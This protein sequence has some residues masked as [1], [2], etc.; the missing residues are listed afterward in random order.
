[1]DST[2]PSGRIPWGEAP[3]TRCLANFR[4]SL[5]DEKCPPAALKG[6]DGL[7]IQ[8]NG[9]FHDLIGGGGC[10]R[11]FQKKNDERGALPGRKDFPTV[12][13]MPATGPH[14]TGKARHVQG[15]GEWRNIAT[16]RWKLAGYEVAGN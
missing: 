7:V 6:H 5:W 15:A 1:M 8:G 10:D 9:G 3:D 4:L 14:S 16:R 12:A 11:C 2:V 13:T